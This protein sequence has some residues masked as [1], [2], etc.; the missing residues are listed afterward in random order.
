MNRLA[1]RVREASKLGFNR[2]IV[3]STGCGAQVRAEL[4]ETGLAADFKVIPASSLAVALEI[5]LH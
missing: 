2:C 5:A 1:L 3:P 4:E